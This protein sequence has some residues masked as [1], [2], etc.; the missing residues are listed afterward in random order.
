METIEQLKEATAL[1]SLKGQFLRV[2]PAFCRLL[3][4]SQEELL[5]L[6][7]RDITHPDDRAQSVGI[8]ERTLKLQP[9]TVKVVKR[10]IHREGHTIWALLT[11]GL[12][13]SP[14]GKESTYF[15]SQLENLGERL[16]ENGLLQAFAHRV[17]TIAEHE[18][19]RIARELHDDLGQVFTALKLEVHLLEDRVKGISGEETAR[20][21]DLVGESMDCLKRLTKSLRPPIL[22]DLGLKSALEWLTKD[23]CERAGLEWKFIGPKEPLNLDGEIRISV[24]RI[25]QE[26]LNNVLR[27]SQASRVEVQL[28][29]DEASV[30]LSVRDNGVGLPGAPELGIGLLGMRE[31]AEI[32]GGRFEAM[33]HPDGGTEVMA[34]FPLPTRADTPPARLPRE[35]WE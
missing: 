6:T 2:N 3:G 15:Y 5:G 33:K 19:Q 14:E 29:A 20:I 35:H 10:Y 13:P 9:A 7:V 24:F 11:T 25:C 16:A 18:R 28:E 27:H 1:V 12:R 4:F 22:D 8:V 34:R 31:R 23:L 30:R 32:L 21:L 26:A 17:Q